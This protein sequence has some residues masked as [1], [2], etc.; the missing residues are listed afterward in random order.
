MIAS[1]EGGTIYEALLQRQ[2]FPKV[3]ILKSF[4]Y[5]ILINNTYK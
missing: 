3:G 1:S 4:A 5:L 2:K